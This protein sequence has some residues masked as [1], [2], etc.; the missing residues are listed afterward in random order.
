MVGSGS[1]VFALMGYIIANMKPDKVVG[2][3][4]RLNA[5]LLATIIGETE[6]RMQE[7]I[8]FLCSPDKNSTSP[9][10]QGRRLVKLGT[11]DYRVV[12]GAKY[13]AI[14][15]EEERREKNRI[16]VEEHRAKEKM[17]HWRPKRMGSKAE[18]VAV[19]NGE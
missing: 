1:H 7:A 11:F 3:Q 13:Q 19:A 15:N 5:T 9:D 17:K 2:A 18:Q 6:H 8:D 4:V 12:N 16:R 14:R 10:E